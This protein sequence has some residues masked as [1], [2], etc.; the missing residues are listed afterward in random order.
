MHEGEE[1]EEEEEDDDDDDDDDDEDG[2]LKRHS[3]LDFYFSLSLLP[4]FFA[5]LAS[6][7]SLTG[8]SVGFILVGKVFRKAFRILAFIDE[9]RGRWALE[10]HFQGNFSGQCYLDFC[11]FLRCP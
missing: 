11:L 3:S 6:F 4:S 2:G 1:E 7:F 8:H 5:F 9:S 10:Q